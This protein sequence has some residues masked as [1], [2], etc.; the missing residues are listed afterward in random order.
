MDQLTQLKKMEEMYR[1]VL[2]LVQRQMIFWVFE[3]R[4]KIP[5]NATVDCWTIY[6]AAVLQSE[7]ENSKHWD[8]LIS[9]YSVLRFHCTIVSYSLWCDL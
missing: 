4:Q 8:A 3:N 6:K 5:L 1:K 7:Q 2:G 9:Y